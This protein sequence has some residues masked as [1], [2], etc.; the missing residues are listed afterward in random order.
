MVVARRKTSE[1]L[2]EY[3]V[4]HH[5]FKVLQGLDLSQHQEFQRL[6]HWN[7]HFIAPKPKFDIWSFNPQGERVK[8]KRN[9]GFCRVQLWEEVKQHLERNAPHCWRKDGYHGNC[10]QRTTRE[11]CEFGGED[12][13]SQP[14]QWHDEVLA[15]RLDEFDLAF[16]H[17]RRDWNIDYRMRR[18]VRDHASIYRSSA[19]KPGHDE[20]TH[21]IHYGLGKS[22]MILKTEKILKGAKEYHNQLKRTYEIETQSSERSGDFDAQQDEFRRAMELFNKQPEIL[23][24]YKFHALARRGLI[25]HSA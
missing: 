4:E 25:I 15:I 16:L 20:F 12:I 3:S 8:Q 11:A 9:E 10:E 7:S 1:E 22:D 19:M 24:R 6:Q 17:S 21:H 23:L 13:A 5:G 14:C 2:S 18:T